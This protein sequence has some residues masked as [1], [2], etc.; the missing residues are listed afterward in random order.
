MAGLAFPSADAPGAAPAVDR[1]S[2]LLLV[3]HTADGQAALARSDARVIAR[4]G[5]F[6]LTE[7]SGTDD[8]RLRE[9]GADRRDDMREVGLPDAEIDPLTQRASLAA[10]SA[11]DRE[12]VL[13]V[14]QFVGPVKE[15]W[16]GRLKA[17]GAQV[18]QYVPEN[19]YLVLGSGVEVDRLAG[20]VGTDTAVRA[21]TPVTAGDKVDAALTAGGVR[22]VAVQTVAG[23]AGGTARR[24]GRRSGR[25][26]APTSAVGLLRTQFLALGG[27]SVEALAADPGVVSITPWSAPELHDERAAQIVAGNVT[28][29]GLPNGPGYLGWLTA[30]SS[31]ARYS[32]SPSTSPTRAWIPGR[33]HRDTRTSTSTASS[34]V[35][36]ACRT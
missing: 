20:L 12:E 35:R 19:G 4:Y 18:V 17:T 34:P 9:A 31:T 21:V 6:T 26:L 15:A 11:P 28:D 7:A 32:T 23:E 13:A 3:P 29:S 2:H 8:E 1:S 30:R 27:A 10:K 25:E 5:E 14:V 16:L 33:R 36:T 24:A 22:G